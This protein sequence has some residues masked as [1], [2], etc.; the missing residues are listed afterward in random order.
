MSWSCQRGRS[1]GS[2]LTACFFGLAMI[3][4]VAEAR[5]FKRSMYV[6]R[7]AVMAYGDSEFAHSRSAYSG[8]TASRP[9]TRRNP[10]RIA[11]IDSSAAL[12]SAK[13]SRLVVEARRWIG[14]NPTGRH[15]L[16]CGHF[17]NFVLTRAGYRAHNSNLA[18]S[19]ASY[20]R[21]LSGPQIGAIAVMSRGAYGGHVGV[22]TGIDRFGNPIIVSGNVSKHVEE[23]PFPRSRI[24]AY[25]MP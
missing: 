11:S 7:P 4:T 23:I 3:T 20:G 22:V 8:Y 24:L 19:F 6:P 2:L 13:S 10:R 16:W 18:R 5:P 17:M 1:L 15:S 9:A 25:V 12:G 21:P 14:T